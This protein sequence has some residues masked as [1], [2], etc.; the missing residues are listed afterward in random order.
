[1]GAERVLLGLVQSPGCS[2]CQILEVVMVSVTLEG[3]KVIW[4]LQKQDS[5]VQKSQAWVQLAG[6][7]YK[8]KARRQD[9]IPTKQFI[10]WGSALHLE[11][12]VF[13]KAEL[14]R[15]LYGKA[16]HAES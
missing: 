9:A 2:R 3:P 7:D 15:S 14:E 16:P 13:V 12:G 11:S 5:S 10:S 4:V 1:M 8:I 6:K